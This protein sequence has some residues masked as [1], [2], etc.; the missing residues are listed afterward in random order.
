MARGVAPALAYGNTAVIKPSVIAPLTNVE[1]GR[2]VEQAGLPAG[3][4]NIVCGSGALC[5]EALAGNPHVKKI[6]FTGSLEARPEGHG[7]R[8]EDPHARFARA[9]RKG[10]IHRL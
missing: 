10:T 2:L 7:T 5:G 9:R 8:R 1:F 4:V 6:V 3:V